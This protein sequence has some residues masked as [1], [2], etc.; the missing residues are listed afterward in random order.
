M[1]RVFTAADQSH[2]LTAADTLTGGPV[3]PGFVLP[4]AQLFS[5]LDRHG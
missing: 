1:V 2:D 5:E 3:L 4:L